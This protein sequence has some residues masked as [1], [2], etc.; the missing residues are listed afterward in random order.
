MSDVFRLYQSVVVD[1]FEW[2]ECEVPNDPPSHGGF[3]SALGPGAH[4]T[5]LVAPVNRDWNQVTTLQDDRAAFRN[6]ASLEPTPEAILDFANAHGML[7]IEKLF[8]ESKAPVRV[9]P[10]PYE[11]KETLFEWEYQIWCMR[12]LVRL[13]D[14]LQADEQPLLQTLFQRREKVWQLPRE[15]KLL[16]DHQRKNPSELGRFRPN[17][18]D[19]PN[20]FAFSMLRAMVSSRLRDAVSVGVEG[21]L[22]DSSL[23][24]RVSTV[25]DGLW[26]QFAMAIGRHLE[27]RA[28]DQCGTWY[29]LSPDVHRT[30]RIYCSNRCKVKAYRTKKETARRMRVENK[31]LREIEKAIGA[32]TAAEKATLK[33]WL[34]D[35]P[36]GGK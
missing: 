36:K 23:S 22:I 14:A 10:D 15:H 28:C 32:E 7:G 13:W 35:I 18:D 24:L 9:G 1:G 6:F 25:L 3:K 5:E 19:T 34:K 8:P 29:E 11:W 26:L 31:S 27:F 21:D 17:T 30:T 12:Y 16:R 20:K 33:G 2:R 4:A